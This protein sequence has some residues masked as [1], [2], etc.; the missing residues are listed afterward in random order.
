[1]VI[2]T[3]PF[4]IFGS[5]DKIPVK[6]NVQIEVTYSLQKSKSSC[7]ISANIFQ[8]LAKFWPKISK[9]FF[10][11]LILQEVRFICFSNKINNTGIVIDYRYY[12]S[13]FYSHDFNFLK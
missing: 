6:G 5:A 2:I 13:T 9:C 4:I 3:S 7:V 12:K 10:F 1:M 11:S 8:R